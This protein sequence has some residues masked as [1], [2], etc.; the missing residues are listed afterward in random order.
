MSE[1]GQLDLLTSLS[2]APPVSLSQSLDSEEDLGTAAATF[3]SGLCSWWMRFVP[4]SWSG[5]TS[6]EYCLAEEDGTLV[7]YSG[8]WSNAGMGGPTESWTLSTSEWPRDGAVCSLS[9]VLEAGPLPQKYYLSVKACK[10]ILR[11]AK[12]RGKE[13]PRALQRALSQVAQSGP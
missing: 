3:P 13:L 5:K 2:E 8:A 4:P 12:K 7:P 9:D 6:P 11:R 1:P 10:G